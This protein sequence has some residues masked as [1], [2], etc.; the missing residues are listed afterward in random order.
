MTVVTPEHGRPV[1]DSLG[2]VGGG[3]GL[4][5]MAIKL[6]RGVAH[7]HALGVV[8]GNIRASNV[9]VDDLRVLKLVD[10]GF[11]L[12][13]TGEDFTPRT[14]CLPWTAPELLPDH[15]HGIVVGPTAE[16]DVYGLGM[17][18]LEMYT[19]QPPFF[20][21]TDGRPLNFPVKLKRQPSLI[22]RLT[23]PGNMPR[24]VWYILQACWNM[25]PSQRPTAHQV[26][27][28]LEALM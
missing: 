20:G 22:G 7:L 10:M 26:L 1:L 8:H 13:Y 17:T 9:L 23:R 27:V 15:Q 18:I 28:W 6:T 24:G 5:K 14:S 11:S 19:R 4:L 25:D 12:L 3:A 21:F 16:S 2:V